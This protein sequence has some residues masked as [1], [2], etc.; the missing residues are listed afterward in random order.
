MEEEIYF[1]TK[2]TRMGEY[3]PLFHKIPIGIATKMQLIY[4]ERY[5]SANIVHPTKFQVVGGQL[6]ID[7]FDREKVRCL[8]L[9]V[10]KLA[11]YTFDGHHIS[12]PLMYYV[13]SLAMRTQMIRWSMI[14]SQQFCFA[15]DGL[16][17][18]Y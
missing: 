12:F 11:R 3:C 9:I 15:L 14:L 17:L 8:S 18:I 5:V 1:I 2:F 16:S 7:S 10:T 6:R 4:V 13:Y